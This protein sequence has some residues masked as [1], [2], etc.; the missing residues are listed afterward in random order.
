M[1]P[2]PY[3]R[4]LVDASETLTSDAVVPNTTSLLLGLSSFKLPNLLKF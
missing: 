4:K 1:A 3:V 2:R